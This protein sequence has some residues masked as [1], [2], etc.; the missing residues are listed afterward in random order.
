MTEGRVATAGVGGGRPPSWRLQLALILLAAIAVRAI[1]FVG[2]GLG[3]DLGYLDHVDRILAGHYPSLDPLNRYAYRPLLLL[4][5]AGGVALFGHTELGIVAPVLLS[6]LTT[7]ALVFALVWNLI[8]RKAAWW[9]ALLYACEPFDVV[10]STTMTNDVILSCLGVR[11]P[12][13]CSSSQIKKL[14][15]TKSIRLF[16]ASGAVMVAAFLI[17]IAVLPALCALGLYSARDA[18]PP[19]AH[20]AWETRRFLR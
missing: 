17:K 4:L 14:A 5:F 15:A 13:A 18:G 19:A 9:C 16:A 2:F 20:R 3:D 6:S 10:N 11:R 12:S 7:S 1:F 8:D